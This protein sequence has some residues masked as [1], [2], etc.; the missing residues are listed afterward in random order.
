MEVICLHAQTRIR[1]GFSSFTLGNVPPSSSS[2]LTSEKLSVFS[3]LMMIQGLFQGAMM[4]TFICGSCIVI[5]C[6]EGE[7]IR[8]GIT[9]MS[10]RVK[11]LSSHAWLINL[12]LS[13]SSM[14]LA[15]IKLL[16]SLTTAL[17]NLL[18][19]LAPTSLSLC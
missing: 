9:L 11:M 19:I 3:G 7:S 4:Q 14:L 17:K 15:M 12:T 1:Y 2:R 8:K 18:V 5:L 16:K 6:K 13:I 10:S